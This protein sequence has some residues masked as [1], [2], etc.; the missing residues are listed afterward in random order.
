MRTTRPD[1]GR[2]GTVAAW[3]GRTLPRVVVV[4]GVLSA[5]A[6]AVLGCRHH[7]ATV[8]QYDDPVK[9]IVEVSVSGPE[10][11]PA[12]A[13]ITVEVR[14]TSLADAPSETLS[15]ARGVVRESGPLAVVE[16][17]VADLP[18]HGA[19]VWA[20]VD[21]DEDGRVS[22]GDYLTTASH[23]VAGGAEVTLPVTVRRI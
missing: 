3:R 20:H 9:V 4:W 10:R 17:E 19:T 5:L 14:D 13:P 11:P 23:P 21:V 12:G 1:C 6:G 8:V 7:G 16:L 15:A 2:S 22:R 18:T